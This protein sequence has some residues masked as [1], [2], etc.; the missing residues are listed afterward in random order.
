MQEMLALIHS[1]LERLILPGPTHQVMPGV[2]WGG[3][4]ELFTPAYWRGQVWQALLADRYQSLRLG[5]N[6]IEEV[7]A[8]LLGGYGMPAELGLAAFDRL[9]ERG[10]LDQPTSNQVLEADLSEPLI[11]S[12]CAVRYRFPRQKARHLSA[13]LAALLEF[14][15]PERDADLR[16]QLMRLPG[17]GPKTASWI[18]RNHRQSNDVAILDVHIVRAGA[19]MGIMRPDASPARDYFGLENKF[20]EFA[21]AIDVPAGILDGLMWQHMRLLSSVARSEMPA[22]SQG[23]PSL[24]VSLPRADDRPMQ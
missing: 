6:L 14:D 24:C 12:G 20:L 23:Y 7:A 9:R 17:V 10:R 2:K 18:V 5:R 21:N 8:C 16:N 4:D 11:I 15:E 13:C 1:K 3:F 19:L 22:L